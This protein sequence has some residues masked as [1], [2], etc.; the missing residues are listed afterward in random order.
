VPADKRGI[1]IWDLVTHRSGLPL[2]AGPDFDRVSRAEFIAHVMA[3]PLLFAP[4]S[5]Q[6]YSNVG[7][8]MLAAIIELVT[9]DTYGG[10]VTKNI[11]QPLGMHDT[12]LLLVKWDTTRLAHG[13]Q[14]DEDRGTMLD[15]PHA[16]DG[17]YWNLRGAGG[18]LSTVSD[19]YRFYAVLFD[20]TMLLAPSS[21]DLRFPR[22][23]AMG[24]AGSDM[25]NFFLYE[26]APMA[27]V[28]MIL[29]SN[30]SAYPVPRVRAGVAAAFG[31]P[32][33][34]T[35]GP[36]GRV[37]GPPAAMTPGSAKPVALPETPA[38]RRAAEYLAVFN[39]RDTAAVRRFLQDS[40]VLSPDDHRT[41][42]QRMSGY[43]GMRSQ[44]G[45]MTPVA[46]LSSTTDQ[47]VVRVIT[48]QGEPVTLTVAV[49]PTTPNRIVRFMIEAG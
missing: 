42:E 7:Y 35:G 44:I 11:W 30:S 22:D 32:T 48:E 12:G 5:D 26:R 33:M 1:T 43:R 46:I 17:P 29:A 4:E 45:I 9:G 49:E 36:A 47:I 34:A 39:A 20:S 18:Y 38:G 16:D 40:V 23:R 13:Y 6:R 2:Y 8:N 25:I 37:G 3:M 21:R 41:I 24:L 10:Y 19:M 27:G 15:R 14:G 31:L 28:V